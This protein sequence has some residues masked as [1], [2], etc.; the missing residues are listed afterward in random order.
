MEHQQ[1]TTTERRR[2]EV[3]NDNTELKAKIND[4]YRR[5]SETDLE[6]GGDKRTEVRNAMWAVWY[7]TIPYDILL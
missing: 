3:E 4:K 7:G 5:A 2:Y 1:Q 6:D